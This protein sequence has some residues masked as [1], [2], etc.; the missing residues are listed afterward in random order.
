MMPYRCNSC[1]STYCCLTSGP[2]LPVEE[3]AHLLVNDEDELVGW[4]WIWGHPESILYW[5]SSGCR[6]SALARARVYVRPEAT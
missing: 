2:W 5:T 4:D 6:P 3:P 1:S